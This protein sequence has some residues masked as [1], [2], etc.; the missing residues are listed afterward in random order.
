MA[1]QSQTIISAAAARFGTIDYSQWQAIRWQWY[2]FIQYPTAGASE[3]IFFGNV[4]GQSGVTLADTNL[5]KAGSFGQQHF[6]LKSI[7]TMIRLPSNDLDSMTVA[8][9]DANTLASDFLNGFVQ[10]GVLDLSIGSRPFAVIPKPFQYCPSAAA[11]AQIANSYVNRITAV[12]AGNDLVTPAVVTQTKRR[13][14]VYRTDPNILIE[15]EQQFECK[16]KFP[17]G[18][19]PIIGTG[20]ATAGSTALT[21]KVGV[22]FDGVLLRPK[23]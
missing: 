3:L 1:T 10:A 8:A 12:P 23:S 20:V 22:V 7:S 5:P 18:A 15:A 13:A 21:L 6:L 4:L 19:V 2:S 17:S 9:P 11:E 14:N 16:I